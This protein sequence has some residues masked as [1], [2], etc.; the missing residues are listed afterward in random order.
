MLG[1][2]TAISVQR[3]RMLNRQQTRRYFKQIRR[4]TEGNGVFGETSGRKMRVALVNVESFEKEP[5]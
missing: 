4:D 2:L 3:R 5:G 1:A